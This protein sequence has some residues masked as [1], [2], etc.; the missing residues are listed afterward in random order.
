MRLVLVL[1]AA[2]GFG[3]TK[4]NAI[5]GQSDSSGGAPGSGGALGS[6]GATGTGGM[7]G[8]TGDASADDAL[9]AKLAAAMAEWAAAKPRCP[10][11]SY[12]T[13]SSSF[14]GYCERTTVEI[15][16]DQPV[17]RS[18]L[19]EQVCGQPDAG[20]IDDWYE[21]GALVGTHTD[22]DPAWTI[23]QIFAACQT[24]LARGTAMNRLSLSIGVDGVPSSCGYTPNGCVDD[25]THDVGVSIFTCLPGDAGTDAPTD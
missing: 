17:S 5:G 6:G 8:T 25:C 16:Y 21:V 23:E 10:V 7:G 4:D 24:V 11:Y 18:Y 14:T 15:A 3:C 2:L 22:G 12:V 20:I 1:V 19:A 13:G 9:V